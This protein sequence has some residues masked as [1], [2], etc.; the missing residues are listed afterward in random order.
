MRWADESEDAPL[1]LTDIELLI[2]FQTARPLFQIGSSMPAAITSGKP[3]LVIICSCHQS[4]DGFAWRDQN[5]KARLHIILGNAGG[6]ILGCEIPALK[7]IEDEQQT[8][9]NHAPVLSR[10]RF[11]E[12]VA[13]NVDIPP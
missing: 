11:Q 12:T 13:E 5:R 6:H 7:L 2:Q 4:E 3:G 1:Y 8:A 9:L 10:L